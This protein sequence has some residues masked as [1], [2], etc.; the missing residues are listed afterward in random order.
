M[1]KE[2]WEKEFDRTDWM[3]NSES[4]DE[5]I[6]DFIRRVLNNAQSPKEEGEKCSARE[7]IGGESKHPDFC[8]CLPFEPEEKQHIHNFKP[9][10]GYGVTRFCDCG[11]SKLYFT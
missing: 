3:A 7:E 10:L 5:D 4:W 8:D 6:K 11:A 2:K 9:E 1:K